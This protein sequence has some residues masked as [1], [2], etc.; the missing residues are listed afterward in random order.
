MNLKNLLAQILE[1]SVKILS[2]ISSS[3]HEDVIQKNAIIEDDNIP[4]SEKISRLPKINP[5]L[6]LGYLLIENLVKKKLSAED[7]KGKKT[8]QILDK[9]YDN[10]KD[11]IDKLLLLSA[12]EAMPYRHLFYLYQN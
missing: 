12:D 6:H 8:G 1:P 11:K 10:N 3:Y 9:F 7:K 5:E 4:F 2:A